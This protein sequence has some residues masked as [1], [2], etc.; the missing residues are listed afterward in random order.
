[1]AIVYEYTSNIIGFHHS[2]DKNPSKDRFKMHAHDE[3]ELLYFVSGNGIFTIEGNTYS[4]NK[5]SIFLMK[6]AEIHKISVQSDTPYER[7][8]VHFKKEALQNIDPSGILTKVFDDRQMG[9]D[10]VYFSTEF[11][12]FDIKQLFCAMECDGESDKKHLAIIFTSIL[13]FI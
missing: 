10:N 9:E 4:L 5:D 3:Y 8:V 2:I 12:G 7:M 6:P 11:D 13:R 1:M